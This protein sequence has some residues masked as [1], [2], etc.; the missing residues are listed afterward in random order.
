MHVKLLVHCSV[1]GHYWLVGARLEWSDDV[2]A[3]ETE[4]N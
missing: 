4:W 1:I 2:S 3:A